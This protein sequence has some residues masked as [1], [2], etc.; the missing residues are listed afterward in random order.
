MVEFKTL[1]PFTTE[2]AV[3]GVTVGFIEKINP[4]H[5]LN[6]WK[7]TILFNE[8]TNSTGAEMVVGDHDT[9]ERWVR[10]YLHGKI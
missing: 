8:D 7:V 6:G 5:N 1:S 3:T 2:I 9:A 10:R 4:R